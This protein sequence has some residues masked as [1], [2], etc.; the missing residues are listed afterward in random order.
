VI[1]VDTSAWVEFLRKTGS[2]VHLLLRRLIEETAELA[3]TEIVVMELSP[4]DARTST[5][6]SFGRGCL[7]FR[8]SR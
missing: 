8:C 4:E 5:P 3:I 6:R 1:V 2:A 7:P